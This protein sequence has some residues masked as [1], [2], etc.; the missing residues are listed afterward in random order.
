MKKILFLIMVIVAGFTMFSSCERDDICPE[1]T[2]TTPLMILRFYD[3]SD[4]SLIKPVSGLRVVG[5][6]DDDTELEPAFTPAASDSIALPLRVFQNTTRFIFIKDYVAATDTAPEQ[7]NRDTLTF[8][9]MTQEVFLNRACGFIAN[10]N[11]D[12]TAG[13]VIIDDGDNWISDTLIEND[14][15]INNQNAAHVRIFH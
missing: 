7:G 8:N 9:Y 3:A 5:L 14:G 15:L 10:Y 11:L 4:T 12:N 13:V 1:E 6:N 2:P